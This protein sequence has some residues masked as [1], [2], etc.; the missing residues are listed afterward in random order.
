MSSSWRAPQPLLRRRSRSAGPVG[1][2]IDRPYHPC[3]DRHTCKNAESQSMSTSKRP[4]DR[5]K[6][7]L[8][9]SPRRRRPSSLKCPS[10]HSDRVRPI[11]YGLP[12]EELMEEASRER[13]I[14]GGC[15][16]LT[17][18]LSSPVWIA[19]I[20]GVSPANARRE[21]NALGATQLSA[22]RLSNCLFDRSSSL[23]RTQNDL[24]CHCLATALITKEHRNLLIVRK[25]CIAIA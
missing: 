19:T 5:R 22:S 15:T 25:A 24:N 13:V 8:P 20:D 3:K 4:A 14:L 18:V 9:R 16:S 1:L 10:C 11:V 12:G 2:I 7:K 23:R 17:V 21:Q 6:S